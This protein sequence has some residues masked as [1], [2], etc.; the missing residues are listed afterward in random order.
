MDVQSEVEAFGIQISRC[1]MEISAG[2]LCVRQLKSL[3]V[4]SVR[5]GQQPATSRDQ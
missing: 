4:D 3:L 5:R 1:M 2:W